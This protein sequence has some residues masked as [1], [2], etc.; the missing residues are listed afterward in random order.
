M[1][2]TVETQV[3]HE[4]EFGFLRCFKDSSQY[5][6]LLP[7]LGLGRAHV[8]HKAEWIPECTVCYLAL[9]LFSPRQTATGSIQ[10]DLARRVQCSMQ[11]STHSFQPDEAHAGWKSG[12]VHVSCRGLFEVCYT[13]IVQ[14]IQ[15]ETARLIQASA[16]QF[17]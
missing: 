5:G 1:I 3:E 15:D 11:C 17:P 16:L 13:M 2:R 6:V 4:L 8:L 12:Q 14:G 10:T 7:D 9:K